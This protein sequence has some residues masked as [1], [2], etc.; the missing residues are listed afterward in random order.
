M[1]KLGECTHCLHTQL[2]HG[3]EGCEHKD[4]SCTQLQVAGMDLLA[5]LRAALGWKAAGFNTAT[6][7]ECIDEVRQRTES[8]NRFVQMAI[9]LTAQLKRGK[10]E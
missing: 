7:E 4:C 10:K 9:E 6:F 2:E 3:F 5:S 1:R 8:L